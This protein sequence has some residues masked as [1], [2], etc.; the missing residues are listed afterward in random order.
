MDIHGACDAAEEMF[1]SVSESLWMPAYNFDFWALPYLYGKGFTPASIR[2]FHVHAQS[3]MRFNDESVAES[4][5]S[6][7]SLLSSFDSLNIDPG[8]LERD[9]LQLA[10]AA[11]SEDLER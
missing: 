5:Q 10:G 6:T 3:L 1:N 7:Q 9:D 2:E 8:L 4:T 11:A